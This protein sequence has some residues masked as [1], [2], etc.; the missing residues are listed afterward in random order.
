ML[1][2][3]PGGVPG[4]EP[5]DRW[6]SAHVFTGHPLDL[7]VSTLIPAAVAEL[8]QRGLADRFFFL[9]HWHGG[10]HLRLRVR[11]TAPAAGPAVRTVLNA[12][13]IAL[14]RTLPPSEP[15]PAHQYRA[16]AEQLAALEPDS[17][18]GTLAPND[19]LAFHPYRP[20]HGKYGHGAALRAAEDAFA[21]CS[22]LA[23][24]AV[25]AG[26]SPAQRT[27]HC[28]A[29]LA[30]TLDAGAAPGQPVPEVL[31]QYRNGRAA[32]LTVARA[33]R[34]AP[35]AEATHPARAAAQSAVADPARAAPLAELADPA[36]ADP[37]S[38]WLATCRGA[39]RQAA[40]PALLAGHLTHLAC[41]RLD[42]RIGQ[43]ATLRALALLAV[44]E[45]T[46]AELTDTDRPRP[47]SD[48][49][50]RHT[51]RRHRGSQDDAP[52]DGAAPP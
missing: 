41:N 16:L 3:P 7:V 34:A 9:R 11:L 46:D 12:H 15:M 31:A 38:R 5:Q 13:A 48:Q 10:P 23:V 39:Q 25:L 49:P 47:E 51:S 28:F 30:G 2:R 22:E 27:A 8:R 1:T 42:V 32:L 43:E 44:V 14:F 35:L 4:P 37:V 20:E 6:V 36:G 19:S 18:P 24:A 29:L 52:H 17:E 33:A 50:R 26:W 21:T 45:L 40:A